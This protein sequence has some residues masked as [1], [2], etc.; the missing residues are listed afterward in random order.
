MKNVKM[1]A[2]EM[3]GNTPILQVN[4]FMEK[5]GIFNASILAKMESVNPAGSI[6]DRA[7]Y[8]MIK[9]AGKEAS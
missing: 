1:S 6:K 8:V 3:I 9:D 5:N 4:N 2:V 7:A